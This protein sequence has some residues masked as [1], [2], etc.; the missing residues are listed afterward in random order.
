MIYRPVG[1]R[2][3]TWSACLKEVSVFV[4]DNPP[5]TDC[6][7]GVPRQTEW[8]EDQAVCALIH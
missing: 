8:R 3:S 7:R 5:S 6:Q 1:T 2:G 4:N